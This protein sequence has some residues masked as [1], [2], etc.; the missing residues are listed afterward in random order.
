MLWRK[1]I[2]RPD[3]KSGQILDGNGN[4]SKKIYHMFCGDYYEIEISLADS[5]ADYSG[6]ELFLG[7]KEKGRFRTAPLLVMARGE[8]NS[9]QKKITFKLSL[10]TIEL[11]KAI[12]DN[13]DLRA[14]LEVRVLD[15]SE[16]LHELTLFQS[17][18]LVLNDVIRGDEL[19]PRPAADGAFSLSNYVAKD[20][21]E[22]QEVVNGIVLNNLILRFPDGKLRRLVPV[23]S[24]G[25]P[26]FTFMEVTDV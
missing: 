23:L 21:P 24:G 2:F 12:G 25:V 8:Y 5:C 22:I 3:V 13:E 20:I 17:E 10:N 7:I 9:E 19:D 16:P 4:P 1:V 14:V 6:N 26:T 11:R 18:I 15:E